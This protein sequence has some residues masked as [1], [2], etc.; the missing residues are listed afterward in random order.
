MNAVYRLMVEIRW[1]KDEGFVN[2]RMTGIPQPPITLED[3]P[4]F[5]WTRARYNRV[6]GT[7][8]LY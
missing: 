1:A 4:D 8:K 7:P 6:R 5:P 2:A 3:V